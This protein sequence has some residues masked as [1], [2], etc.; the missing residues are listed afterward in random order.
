M[1]IFSPKLKRY[2]KKYDYSYTFGT[3]PT[4]DLLRYKKEDVLKVLIHSKND[5]SEGVM[6]V[7]RLCKELNIPIEIQDR[8][9]ESIAYK[10]N[11]YVIGIFKKYESI[12]EKDVNHLVLVEPSNM[13]NIGTIIRTM[14][15]FGVKNL[16]II[17]PAVD[18]FDPK[19]VRSTMG[20]I[21]QINFQYFN[22]IDEYITQHPNNNRYPFMLDGGKDIREVEIKEPFAMIQGNESAGL[23][24]SYKNIGESIYIPYVKDIDSFNLSVAT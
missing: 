2:Q 12:L 8:A 13:G 24:D 6:E 19:V 4:I 11:T 18:I 15:G 7:E 17:K 22:N 5:R 20:A 9:I 3:Y 1:G 14:L 21:F 10:E 16:G 23:P